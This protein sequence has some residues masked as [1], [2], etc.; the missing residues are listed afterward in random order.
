M[1]AVGTGQ[2]ATIQS[3]Q[4]IFLIVLL[5]AL[6]VR[7]LDTTSGRGVVMSNGQ[8]DHRTVWQIDGALYKTFSKRTATYHHT[9]VLILDGTCHNLCGRGCILV[10]QHND[11]SIAETAMF[12]CLIVATVGHASFCIDNQV[13]CLQELTGQVGSCLQIATAILLQVEHQVFHA[14]RLQF[15]HALHELII[16]GGTKTAYADIADAWANH[17][18]SVNGMYGNLVA[19]HLKGEQILNTRTHNT[20]VGNGA[21]GAAQ[22]AHNLF[23]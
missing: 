14:L 23:L 20:Q 6:L 12:G 17:V 13:T 21:L 4:D 8:T 15:L 1:N 5:V 18:G 16:G 9:A 7:L 2:F 3:I 11:A 19:L 22:T 10:H